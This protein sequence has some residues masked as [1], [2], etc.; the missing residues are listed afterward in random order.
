[1]NQGGEKCPTQNKKKTNW[2]SHILRRNCLLKHVLEGKID[3][4]IQKT[5]REGRKCKQLQNELKEK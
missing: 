5:G 1:M 4:K 3:I 2:I